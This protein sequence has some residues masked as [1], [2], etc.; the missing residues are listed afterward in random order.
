MGKT[1]VVAKREYLERVRGKWFV[2]ATVFGPRARWSRDGDQR[3]LELA[4]V[5][6]R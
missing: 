5:A 6:Q 1:F 2:I 3:R 4:L